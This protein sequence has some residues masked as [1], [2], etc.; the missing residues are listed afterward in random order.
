MG[1]YLVNDICLGLYVD[2]SPPYQIL[3]QSD[4]ELWPKFIDV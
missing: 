4:K 3:E 1:V 2:T